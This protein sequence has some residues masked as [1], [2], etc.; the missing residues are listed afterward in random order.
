MENT[1]VRGLYYQVKVKLPREYRTG[2]I[3]RGKS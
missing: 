2:S 1:Q 3:G